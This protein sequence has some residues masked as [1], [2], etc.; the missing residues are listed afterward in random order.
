MFDAIRSN[1]RIVQGIL[2]LIVVTFAFFGVESYLGSIGNDSSLATV[3]DTKIG[4][5]EFENAL[6]RQQDQIRAQFG[7]DI[8]IAQL[9]TPEI[10]RAVLDGLVN[11]RL[12][13]L[14][15]TDSRLA[16]SPEQL[17]QVIGS[18][19][20]FKQDGQFS[21]SRYEQ[22][23]RAQNLSVPQFEAQLRRDVAFQQLTTAVG[24]SAIAARKSA[25][26]LLAL[27]LEE[28][29]VA[30]ARVSAE[31][32]AGEVTVSDDEV[33]TYYQA[34]RDRFRLPARVKADYLVLDRE[35]FI[36]SIK[37]D[38]AQIE[39]WYQA[40]Q[41]RYRREEERSARHI[42]I[43]LGADAPAD[44]VAEA[45]ARAEKIL[46]EVR[47]NGGEKFA[48]VAARESED[49]GS[50]SNG[51]D[52]GF[53]T[54]DAMV[55]P[56][57][58]AVFAL[59]EGGISDIVRSDFGLHV[60]QLTGIRPEQVRP[61]DE[62]RDTIQTELRQ[63]QAAREFAHAAETFSNVVYEQPDSLGPA[64]EQFGLTLKS[65]DWVSRD[66][67]GQPPFDNAR[68]MAALFKSDSLERK[69][70][71]EAVDVGN[72]QLVSA[73]VTTYEPE[74]T[75]AVEEVREEIVGEL[76]LE[77]A[78]KAAEKRGRELL[79][80]LRA[81]EAVEVDFGEAAK[82]T[83]GPGDLDPLIQRELFSMPASTELP[84]YGGAVGSDK[85]FVLFRVES[86]N[87]PEIADDDPRLVA[88]RNQ[89]ERILA[90]RD[91]QAFLA[92]LRRKYKVEI[93]LAALQSVAS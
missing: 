84:A 11:Q 83:R 92:E 86:T 88:V 27:Q 62:V 36:E 70:N 46:A 48:E 75:E 76:K 26:R 51:G 43:E 64:A 55:A 24:N 18:I 5:A 13:A 38:D 32:L 17:R 2:G 14:Y 16:V 7:G 33:Q 8:D 25:H 60:I 35:K 52:L 90:E 42:L 4:P 71:T 10:R 80:K 66:G 63:D 40:H 82:V 49:P 67:A 91:L 54:R 72:G 61:L 45:T 6:R 37:V 15:A 9:N 89:Y 44:E 23:L 21:Q 41:D 59:E 19:D 78:S 73:R 31:E 77:A 65:S 28:R 1:R 87:V 3:G 50:A 12:L 58:E 93:N 81:G 53:F 30:T 69:L 29:T 57:S 39:A 56:F 79:A 68:L 20:E 22:V 74:R 34:N 85:D 47:A